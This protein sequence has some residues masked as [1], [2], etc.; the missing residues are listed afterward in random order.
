MSTSLIRVDAQDH[1]FEAVLKM[2][3]YNV[4]HIPW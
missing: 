2:I 3:K 1:C 4:H